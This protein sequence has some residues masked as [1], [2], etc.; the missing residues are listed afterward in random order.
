MNMRGFLYEIIAKLFRVLVNSRIIV[1]GN[2]TGAS[3]TPAVSCAVRQSMGFLYP[4]EK[5]F[6]YVHKPALYIR[7]EEVDNVHFARSDVSTRSFDFEIVQK[8]GQAIVF[9]NIGK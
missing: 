8:S 9:G 2:F 6:V 3:G 1:P 5:G 4:L 7:F